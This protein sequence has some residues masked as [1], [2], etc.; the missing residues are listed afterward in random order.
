MTALRICVA[1]IGAIGGTLAACL[2][3]GG[4]S[5]SLIARG[6]TLSRLRTDGLTLTE[7]GTRFT[8]RPDAAER[9]PGPADVLFLTVKSHQLSGLLPAVLP[10]IGPDT[11]IVPV[12]NGIPWWMTAGD[13]PPAFRAIVPLLDPTGQLAIHL[14]TNQIAGCVAYAFSTSPA[15]GQVQS[16]R[17]MRL[18]LGPA[19]PAPHARLHKL[20]DLLRACGIDAAVTDA[21]RAEIWT[22]LAG[23]VAS[24]PLS[25]ITGATLAA[26]ATNPATRAIVHATLDEAIAVGT[27]CG[28]PPLKPAGAICDIM[29]AAGAHDTSMLQ[30]FRAGRTLETTAIGDAL[31]GLGGALGVPT[32]V[33]ATLLDLV[34]FQCTSLPVK[35]QTS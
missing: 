28:I 19:I 4:A 1:G 29:A 27:A 2:A 12:V 22:K 34:A 6:E 14:P 21:I 7:G 11:L 32:P 15:P 25:V 20:A 10:A 16:L 31:V 24:N 3:R 26:M 33:T 17:P 30:D 5:V 8:C 9:A 13:A 35:E 18:L 23:N